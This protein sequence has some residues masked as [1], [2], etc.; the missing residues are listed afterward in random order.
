MKAHIRTIVGECPDRWALASFYAALLGMRIIREDWLMIAPNTHSVP[1]L[2][3]YAVTDYRPLRW[4]EP[5]HPQQ[6]HLDILVS[7][8]DTAASP[9]P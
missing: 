1:R 9:T 5:K 2:V 7:D 6:V 3:F 4:P 8:Q